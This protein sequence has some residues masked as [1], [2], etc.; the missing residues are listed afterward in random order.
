MVSASEASLPFG[1]LEYALQR[2][3]Q[4]YHL[5]AQLLEARAAA[6]AEEEEEEEARAC[7]AEPCTADA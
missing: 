7:G 6:A 2:L 5:K 3:D 4:Y 1:H